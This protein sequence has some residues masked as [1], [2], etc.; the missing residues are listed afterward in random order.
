MSVSFFFV[1]FKII[2]SH[3]VLEVLILLA[4]CK[5]D[6]NIQPIMSGFTGFGFL[7]NWDTCQHMF[8]TCSYFALHKRLKKNYLVNSLVRLYISFRRII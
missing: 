6:T 7:I 4:I 1:S 8:K 5:L 2:M 3:F